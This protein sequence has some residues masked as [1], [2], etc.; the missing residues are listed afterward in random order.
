MKK[1]NQVCFLDPVSDFE[2]TVSEF[3][4]RPQEGESIEDGARRTLTI[5]ELKHLERSVDDLSNRGLIA[6]VQIDTMATLLRY[7]DRSMSHFESLEI[8]EG[9]GPG[10]SKSSMGGDKDLKGMLDM[11]M[12]S[13]QHASLS[14]VIL[15][16]RGL[17]QHLFPE[18][19]L[20]TSL[21]VFKTRLEKFLA[22]ALEFSKEDNGLGKGSAVFKSISGSDSLK[23]QMLSLVR[24]TCD[25]AEKLRITGDADLSDDIVVKFV[26]ITLSLFFIDTSSEMMVGLTEAESMKQAGSSLMR[27]VRNRS[28]GG[29]FF[30]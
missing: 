24:I 11:I 4:E 10:A 23:R 27:L 18:E 6:E 12:L 13:L 29:G 8:L 1:P 20:L 5:I 17:A 7:L 19:L 16:A 25:I 14:L 9:D 15:N 30:C 26:Y 28:R 21:S 2:D 22:P 3:L